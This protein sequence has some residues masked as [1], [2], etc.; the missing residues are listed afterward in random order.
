MIRG[1]GTGTSDD[2]PAV[3]NGRNGQ[4]P[5]KLSNGEAYVPPGRDSKGLYALMKQLERKA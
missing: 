5:A 3:I 1:P 4:T 2:I